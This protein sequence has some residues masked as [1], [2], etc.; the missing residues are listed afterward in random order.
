[1]ELKSKS[2]K[3]Y[4]LHSKLKKLGLEF[5][6]YDNVI[7]VPYGTEEKDLP[8]IVKKLRTEFGYSVTSKIE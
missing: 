8:E 3:R 5:N 2:S 1:M 6:A 7:Y 4:Y